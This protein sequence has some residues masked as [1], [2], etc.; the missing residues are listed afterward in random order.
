[1]D[2]ND[3]NIVTVEQSEYVHVL[4][5]PA[6]PVSFPLSDEDKQ[7]IRVMKEKLYSLEGVGLAAPQI[8]VG[9]KIIAIYIPQN[10]ALLRDNI[11]PYP[12]HVLINP[13][14]QP[15]DPKNI[16]YDFEACYSVASIA[17]KVPR[18]HKIALRYFDEEGQIHESDEE[19][20]YARVLQHEIDHINGLLITD[21]LTRDC[22]QG[23]HAEMAKLRRAELSEEKKVLFDSLMEKKFNN[24]K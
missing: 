2:A 8:N 12:M 21:R 11:T 4:K 1:M 17:G 3:L 23:T 7:L 5:T 20:F 16:H 14:Y 10:A 18:F 9:K 19:G 6:S 22:L 15:I 13:S 24:K